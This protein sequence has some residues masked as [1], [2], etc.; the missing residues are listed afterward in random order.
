MT[1]RRSYEFIG[2]LDPPEHVTLI[3]TVNRRV[4]GALKAN[5]RGEAIA[6]GMAAAIFLLGFTMIGVSYK[7]QNPY[8]TTDAAI[9]QGF[10]YWPLR[11]ILQIRLDNLMLQT[12]PALV[13]MVSPRE[14]H[15]LIRTA[16]LERLW[17][18]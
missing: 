1:V 9:L 5:R 8:F 15:R 2:V 3:E 18:K 6:I 17:R 14:A 16:L 13:T 10:L 11:E 7:S 4:D 12:L